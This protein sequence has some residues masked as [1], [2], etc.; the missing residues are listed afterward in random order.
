[1]ADKNLAILLYPFDC[2]NDLTSQWS[3]I[4]VSRMYGLPQPGMDT[5]NPNFSFPLQSAKRT[6]SFIF[7]LSA[8]SLS[9]SCLAL[10]L[11]HKDLQFLESLF[12]EILN[13]LEEPPPGLPLTDQL[14]EAFRGP[15]NSQQ[16]G[17]WK[18]EKKVDHQVVLHALKPR[19]MGFPIPIAGVGL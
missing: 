10:G 1:M 19:E 13:S 6:C 4:A 11:L 3:P 15:S 8:A 16:G 14:I 18:V 9:T 7:N 12:S 5:A 2:K 17:R